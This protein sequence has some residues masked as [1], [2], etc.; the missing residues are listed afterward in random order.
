MHNPQTIINSDNIDIEQGTSTT[1]RKKSRA[2]TQIKTK[3]EIITKLKTNHC[4]SSRH[5]SSVHS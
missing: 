3:K 4:S 5:K 2:E 1:S